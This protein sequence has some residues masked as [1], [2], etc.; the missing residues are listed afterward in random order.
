MSIYIGK[1]TSNNNLVHIT[2]GVTAE[3]SI[4]GGPISNTVFHSRQA[5]ASFRLIPISAGTFVPYNHI[6]NYNSGFNYTLLSTWFI[7]GDRDS[8]SFI[9]TSIPAYGWHPYSIGSAD[10]S[11]LISSLSSRK[12]RI[13]FLDSNYKILSGIGIGN[14]ISIVGNT[15][16]GWKWSTIPSTSYGF[17]IVSFQYA[18]APIVSYILIIDD[19][20]YPPLSG[21]ITIN[22]TGFYIGSTNI[23]TDRKL[24]TTIPSSSSIKVTEELYLTTA[25]TAGTGFELV[26]SPNISIK[27]GGTELFNSAKSSF[28][29]FKPNTISTVVKTLPYS[30]DYIDTLIYTMDST[31]SF[32]VIGITIDYTYRQTTN[33]ALT[34]KTNSSI[35]LLG[36]REYNTSSGLLRMD[37]TYLYTVNGSVYIRTH[38]AGGG[39]EST[40]YNFTLSIEAF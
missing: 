39:S 17:G 19:T 40:N 36:I 34:T 13:L 9:Y 11:Y 35:T 7:G 6:Y 1:D 20:Y 3:S 4:K 5:L 10:Y 30:I 25:P 8:D 22:N 28:M 29:P 14:M 33:Y 16:Y 27:V 26:T 2:Q 23:F 21:T 15:Q 32:C 37:F 12:N 31:E 24:V 18:D 38:R